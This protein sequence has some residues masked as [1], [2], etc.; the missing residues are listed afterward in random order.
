MDGHGWWMVMAGKLRNPFQAPPLELQLGNT[1][2]EKSR[3]APTPGGANPSERSHSLCFPTTLIEAFKVAQD[4]T[5]YSIQSK[6]M[7]LTIS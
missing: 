2:N 1:P 7:Y 5:T 4:T 3:L 6:C